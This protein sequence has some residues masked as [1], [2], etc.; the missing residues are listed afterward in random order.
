MFATRHRESSRDE[1]SDALRA[2]TRPD[3]G[4]NSSPNSLWD[5]LATRTGTGLGPLL[6]PMES[7]FSTDFSAVRL[8]HNASRALALNARAATEGEDIHLAPGEGDASKTSGRELIGHELAHVVQQRRS[9]IRS[10][11]SGGPSILQSRPLES[12]AADAGH[13]AAAGRTVP[14]PGRLAGISVPVVQ[15]QGKTTQAAAP[16]AALPFTPLRRFKEIWPEFVQARNGLDLTKT[17]ALARELATAPFDS[18]DLLTHGIEVVAWLQRNGEPALASRLLSDIRGVSMIGFVTIGGALPPRQIW[19]GNNP[20]ALI[21]LGKEAARAGKHDQAFSFFGAANEL[22][23]Y[24]ALRASQQ[25]DTALREESEED[26]RQLQA[27]KDDPARRD[28][29]QFARTL[30]RMIARSF[31][32][33]AL[34]DIYDEMREI[35]GFYYVLEREALA[36]GDARGA[37][38]ARSTAADLHREIKNKYTW[39]AT[40]QQGSISQEIFEPVEIAEVSYAETPKGPGLTLHGAISADTTLTQ[41]P[42]L[43]SPKEIGN[44]VQVQNLGALQ[45]ALMAQTDF[46]AEIGR[47]PEI[48]KAFGDEPVDLNDTGKRQK[49]WRIMYGVYRQAGAGALGS[50]MSLTGRYLKAFTIHTMYNVRD[51]GKSYLDT[52]MPTDLA[53]RAERDCG[54]YALTVAWD[55][56]QT[57]KR[58]DSKLEVTFDLTTML[59]HVTLVITDKSTGEYYVVNNDQ[60]SPPQ[61]GDPLTQV[62]RQYG[63]VRGLPYA[64]G[65]AVTMKLGSTKD[66]SKK[67]HDDMW[68]RYLAAVDWGLKPDIPPDVAKLEKADPAAYTQRV[69]AIRQARYEAFYGDQET[70]DQGVKALDPLVDAL[71]PVAGDVAKFAPAL[72]AVVDKAGAL[73]VLFIRLGPS[74]GVVA[75]SARSQALLPRQAQ[76]L[77]TMEQGH[78]VHPIARVAL[79]ILHLK[80]LGGTLTPKEDALVKFCLAVPMFKQQMDAYQATGAFGKF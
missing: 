23:S 25:R 51:W 12:K 64:V 9:G 14:D 15:L 67:F 18:Y 59:E 42:G 49:V 50:L 34:K 62:A 10:S 3:Q 4:Q 16:T 44:N 61:T 74:A 21:T 47:Q 43:P 1:A 45:S 20:S 33:S 2:K 54:V 56:Y 80:A 28:A 52:E 11:H 77:F 17:T 27:K 69:L 29:I 7:A 19:T 5:H 35:Y 48:R 40:Q 26:D 79:G 70:F 75:G 31:Q 55:V 46:Q 57:V 6:T 63:A 71:A 60:V 73:A 66:P 8:H 38:D 39:G 22:L 78:T 13:A 37:A 36:T 53:G 65:P 32:Y 72:D 76:F 58:G 68:T 41:L 24:Y 30:P